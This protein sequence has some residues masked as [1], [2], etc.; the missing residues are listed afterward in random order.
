MRV[1]DVKFDLSQADALAERLGEIDDTA[2]AAAKVR[3]V[4]IVANE[5]YAAILPRMN[6]GINLPQSYLEANSGVREAEPGGQARAV[7]YARGRN[8]RLATY[9]AKQLVATPKRP[10]RAKGDPSRGI[11]KGLK[12]GGVSVQVTRG[13]VSTMTKAFLV[14]LKNGNGMGVFIREGPGKKNIKHLYG[15]SVYQLFK[16][17]AADELDNVQAN[18]EATILREVGEEIERALG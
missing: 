15:P 4:N 16:K 10:K 2:L 8:T 18:L 7:I 17:Q 11:P 6:A 13:T 14:P 5:A 3:A 1:I 12:Q 9:D